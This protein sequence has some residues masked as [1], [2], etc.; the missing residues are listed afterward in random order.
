[1]S[2]LASE[3]VIAPPFP[4]GVPAGPDDLVGREDLL[5]EL[6]ARLMAGQSFLLSGP[7]RT[8]K[9]GVALETIRRLRDQGA[10]VATVDLFHVTSVEGFAVQLMASV[11]TNRTGPWQRAVRSASRLRQALADGRLGARI[12]DLELTLA[13]SAPGAVG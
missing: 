2:L 6:T 10:Y 4:L 7:R 11:P 1:M 12:A 13:L 9:S 3:R 5:A 8:G